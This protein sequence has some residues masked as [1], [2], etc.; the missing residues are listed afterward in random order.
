MHLL[1]RA[2][3]ILFASLYLPSLLA[4]VFVLEPSASS[5]IFEKKILTSFVCRVNGFLQDTLIV[6]LQIILLY[7]SK[8]SFFIHPI[9][10]PLIA[11]IFCSFIQVVILLD[12]FIYKGAKLRFEAP[13]YAF[14]N[15]I[16]CF[17]DSAKEKGIA[18]LYP[19]GG[20]FCAIVPIGFYVMEKA[21]DF[22][23]VSGV[24][25]SVYAGISLLSILGAALLSKKLC[26]HLDN[27]FFAQIVWALKKLVNFALRRQSVSKVKDLSSKKAFTP[28]NEAYSSV[29]SLYPL[30][31]YTKGFYGE[32]QCQI[33]IKE[34]E[35]PHIIFLFL[36]SFRA[37]DVGALGGKYSVT[38][39]FDKLSQE[40]ILF[41]NFY[42]NSVKTSR[43]VTASLFGIPS[44]VSSSE[45]SSRIDMPFISLAH[46]LAKN[47]YESAYH[48]NGVLEFENQHSFFS[49]YGYKHLVGRNEI[50]KKYPKAPLTSWG[51]HDEYLMKYSL[52]W[53]KEKSKENLPLFLTM[54]TISNHHPWV[55]PKGCRPL[56]LPHSLNS[57]YK[58]YLTTLSYTDDCLKHFVNELKSSHLA[59][60]TVLFIL[61][62]HGHP[63]GEHHK[64]F[65][66]QRYLY[67]ENI[68]VPLLIYAQD[69][70]QKPKVIDDVST[71][72]DLIP[73]VMDVL[74]IKGLNHARGSTL[75]RKAKRQVFF[76][77]PYV[78]GFYGT[79][80]GSHKLVYTRSSKEVELFDLYLD[81]SEK[82]NLAYK[83]PEIVESY[84]QD[85]KDYHTY[86]K[87]LYDNKL[88]SPFERVQSQTSVDFSKM[89][90]LNA[91][92]L[93]I[94][95]KKHP[96]ILHLDLSSCDLLD[97]ESFIEMI[98]MHKEIRSL[99]LANCQNLTSKALEKINDHCVRLQFI[100]L[101]SC[102]FDEENVQRFI[103]KAR[104]LE[105]VIYKE[106]DSLFLT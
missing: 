103:E 49:N 55:A 70:I 73:T 58:R 75:L 60:N 81:P 51:V 11:C 42:A 30:L 61:G 32:K 105:Q 87:S 91:A 44:D 43:S 21:A 35:K 31:K 94:E 102:S 64:N 2:E 16:G 17:W 86:Y 77:N 45:I 1:T 62:D 80:K 53:L 52:N 9:I 19:V 99:N 79:R 33:D 96:Y 68:H 54:F 85:V 20:L 37:K 15:D 4:R 34:E 3:A 89:R 88:F 5:L 100:D 71:Q 26:Y 67:E 50:L 10:L 72:I 7:F 47:G 6:F 41:S 106:K 57:T 38:P 65:I 29:S 46:V 36:E 59:K 13:F 8:V 95:L 18:L 14:F 22:S 93:L 48:H 84:L 24:F 104:H 27:A 56:E 82:T 90:K 78:Y 83:Y 97:D 39:Y 40:G 23:F 12:A 76:H 74:N 66:E 63:M 101:S 98:K 92:K 28:Q 25:F 69:R